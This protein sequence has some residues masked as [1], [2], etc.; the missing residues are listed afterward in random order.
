MTF[1][2]TPG[3]SAEVPTIDSVIQGLQTSSSS[4]RIPTVDQLRAQTEA[5]AWATRENILRDA[6]RLLP[7]QQAR[8]AKNIIDQALEAAFP[9]IIARHTEAPAASAPVA[10]PTSSPCPAA[11]RVCVDLDRQVSWL[12]DG[13]GH[14]VGDVV[15][16]SSGA[17]GHPTPAGSYRVTR[18][19]K[20][21]VSREFGNAPMPNAVYFAP[22]G[23]AFHAGDPNI[24]S[25]GCVHLSYDQ[26]QRY[27]DH[28]NVGDL[29]YTW[30]S[31][32]YG[33]PNGAVHR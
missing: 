10:E 26:S 2:F 12:Q 22:G 17:K 21:E 27:W 1:T 25:H 24:L 3:A 15:I 19:V 31:V 18:K 7:P 23:I 33:V 29:V 11:A 5:A 6:D 14:R 30:G 4:L 32:D 9:G 20:N 8:D 28:L 16:I 13:H